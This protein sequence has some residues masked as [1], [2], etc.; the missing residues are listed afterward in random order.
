MFN[1]IVKVS[2]AAAVLLFAGMAFAPAPASA[3]DCCGAAMVQPAPVIVYQ[4]SC[5]GCG[6]SYYYSYAPAYAYPSANY[7]GYGAYA[8]YGYAG[9]GYGYGDG[10]GY[11]GY[12]AAISP[13]AYTNRFYRPRV[14]VGPGRGWVR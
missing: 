5:G 11:A 6:G 14:Y 10:Y 7:G 9:E 12:R 1:R 2:Y 3:G 8:A 4:P 13:Y